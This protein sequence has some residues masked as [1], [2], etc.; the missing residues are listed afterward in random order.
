MLKKSQRETFCDA[1]KALKSVFGRGSILDPVGELTELSDPQSDGG[2]NL[3]ISPPIPHP[4]DATFLML[5]LKISLPQY[6]L[7]TPFPLV[8]FGH[9][10]NAPKLK[11]SIRPRGVPRG[12]M[13][14]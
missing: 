3:F 10:I 1:W 6:L 11:S 8:V 14:V 2:G 13:P 7:F 4:L 5:T 9:S 12:I